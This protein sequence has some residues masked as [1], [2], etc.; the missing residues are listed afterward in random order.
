MAP[1]AKS[2]TVRK[3]EKASC[4]ACHATEV[5]PDA[6]QRAAG[7][8]VRGSRQAIA[9]RWRRRPPGWEC[10]QQARG[11]RRVSARVAAAEGRLGVSRQDR[12]HGWRRRR[13]GGRAGLGRASVCAP[14]MV[15]V[16]AAEVLDEVL[17]C[18][19]RA[20]Q[21]PRQSYVRRSLC[22]LCAIAC[23]WFSQAAT[24]VRLSLAMACVWSSRA[25]WP[26]YDS[27]LFAANIGL[28][29]LLSGDGTGSAAGRW[30][31]FG[32]GAYGGLDSARQIPVLGSRATICGCGRHSRLLLGPLDGLS[33]DG[34]GSAHPGWPSHRAPPPSRSRRRSR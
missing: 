28:C 24:C 7:P 26:L 3:R 32:S 8:P 22:G 15:V 27:L 31:R 18:W 13:A 30:Y 33:G 2:A 25:M 9:N 29:V 16:R 23:V 1:C 10:S 20:P 17:A 6:E 12:A 14:L 4:A 19:R 11:N 21:A 5:L 34:L